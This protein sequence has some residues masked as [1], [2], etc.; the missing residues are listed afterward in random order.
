MLHT[1]HSTYGEI[2]DKVIVDL[3]CGPGILGIAASLI[4]AQ[5]AYL[6]ERLFSF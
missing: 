4:G 5:F 3:G 2:E 1:I 6:F